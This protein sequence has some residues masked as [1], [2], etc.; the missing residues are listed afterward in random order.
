[1]LRIILKITGNILLKLLHPKQIIQR[2]FT[3][4]TDSIERFIYI[5][6]QLS[7]VFFIQSHHI[8]GKLDHIKGNNRSCAYCYNCK[9]KQV[10]FPNYALCFFL[11]PHNI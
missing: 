5:Q 10:D 7:L 8:S 3:S 4:F 6:Q 11:S 2:R 9:K 1:M